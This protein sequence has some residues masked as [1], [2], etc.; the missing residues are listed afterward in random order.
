M[1]S[2]LYQSPRRACA[3]YAC[4]AA[5]AALLGQ[6]LTVTYNYGGSRTA[7]YQTGEHHSP[8]NELLSENIYVFPDTFG[9][10]GQFYHY[11]A[12]DPLLE[13][14]FDRRVDQPRLRWRRILVPGLAHV[15]A[16]GSAEW[17]DFAYQGVILG[18]L[19]LGVYWLGMF[20]LRRG[21]DPAWGLAFL[22]LPATVISLERFTVDIALAALCV[23]FILYAETESRWKLW[24]V[25][26]LAPFARETG[27]LL[28]AAF[29]GLEMLRRR[30]ARA[31]WAAL[32]VVPYL[33]WMWFVHERARPD[34]NWWFSYA[35]FWGM[36]RRTLNPVAYPVDSG[37]AAAA[38]VL[39]YLAVLGVWLALWLTWRLLKSRR[40]LKSKEPGPLEAAAL[41]F[42][43]SVAFLGTPLVWSE[44]YAFSR[45]LSPLLLWLA[46]DG[47]RAGNLW[48]AAPLALILPRIVVQ[49]S[50][51]LPGIA[52]GLLGIS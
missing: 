11:V 47:L 38:A 20:C 51:H 19:G 34:P 30:P 29:G 16:G 10:D 37:K 40:L 21:R 46:M 43:A 39:D 41:V 2:I 33:G 3:A 13:R 1:T 4:L 28:P 45:V 17:I 6:F 48:G 27:V 9:Y 49:L 24:A 23:G 15:L 50:T 25:L 42:A 32:S 52:R 36:L 18:W 5:A 7:L 44:A 26:C 8:P 14:G 22:L 35:P 31:A 12:H